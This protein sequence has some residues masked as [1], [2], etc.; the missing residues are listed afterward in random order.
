MK[1]Y[2]DENVLVGMLVISALGAAIG[3]MMGLAI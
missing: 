1:T 3:I 2:E